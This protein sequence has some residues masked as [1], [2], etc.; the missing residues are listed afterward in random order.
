MGAVR[1]LCFWLL[2][3]CLPGAGGLP[4]AP[5]LVLSMAWAGCR[6]PAG[7][8]VLRAIPAPGRDPAVLLA[9]THSMR[10]ALG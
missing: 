2:L 6:D 3:W 8:G 4:R 10:R 9:C 5:L 1:A 7:A